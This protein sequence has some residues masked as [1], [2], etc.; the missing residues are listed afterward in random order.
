MVDATT[1]TSIGVN[2]LRTSGWYLEF[3]C[4]CTGD[5]CYQVLLPPPLS[6]RGGQSCFCHR[7]ERA[8]AVVVVLLIPIRLALA[9][10]ARR[11]RT[12]PGPLGHTA[13]NGPALSIA[14]RAPTRR[15]GPSSPTDRAPMRCWSRSQAML[16]SSTR[17]RRTGRCWFAPGRPT[18]RQRVCAGLRAPGRSRCICRQACGSAVAA[19][20]PTSPS[21]AHGLRWFLPFWRRAGLSPGHC[22]WSAAAWFARSSPVPTAGSSSG[23]SGEF[24]LQVTPPGDSTSETFVVPSPEQQGENETGARAIDLGDI[25]IEKGV[26]VVVSAITAPV[27]AAGRQSRRRPG[28]AARSHVLRDHD[29]L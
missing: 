14:W 9:R 4:D 8:L 5:R 27:P 25:V 20:R 16:D 28:Q 12:R 1:A 23:S 13:G 6:L 17:Q 11:R 10:S 26:A 19:C 22:V 7:R 2:A 29:Q 24:Q 21:L 15:H 18:A 3:Y